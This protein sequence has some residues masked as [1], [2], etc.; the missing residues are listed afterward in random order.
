MGF[1]QFEKTRDDF[2]AMSCENS[3]RNYF[4]AAMQQWRD[5]AL[6][7]CTLEYIAAETAPFLCREVVERNLARAGATL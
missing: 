6:D 2:D 7:D 1:E 5:G 4:S 3:A